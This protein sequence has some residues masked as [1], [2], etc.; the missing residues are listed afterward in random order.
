LFWLAAASLSSYL[1]IYGFGSGGSQTDSIS[2]CT[3]ILV[4]KGRGEAL[5]DVVWL[6]LVNSLFTTFL[7]FDH[8]TVASSISAS[9][10]VS[11]FFPSSNDS[12]IGGAM[13]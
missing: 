11:L 6:G 1:P 4:P 10:V 3:V 5:D 7:L 2:T 8:A 12:S 13:L 9:F